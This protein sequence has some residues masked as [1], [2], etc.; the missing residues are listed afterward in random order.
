MEIIADLHLH[1]K[2]S[3]ATSPRMNITDL[4]NAAHVKGVNL[5]GTGD[6]THPKHFADLKRDLTSIG[7][8][9][10]THNN[11]FFMLTSEISLMYTQDGKGRR[12]H[13]VT[14]APD[15]EIVE[16]INERLAKWGRLDYD[17]RP[18][19]GRSCIEYVDEMMKIS[20]E[21]EIIPAHC[22]TPFFGLLG[23]MSG[24]N[25]VEECFGEKSKHIHALETGM[26]SDPSMNWRLSS[27]DKYALVSF[28]DSHSPYPWRLGR[29]ACVFDLKKPSYFELTDAIRNKDHKKFLSTIETSPEYGKY[30]YDGHRDCNVSFSPEE[31]KRLNNICPVCKR[32]L[33][34]GVENRVEEL[35][36]RSVGFM[37]KD[38]IPFKRIIPL[39][40]IICGLLKSSVA[41]KKTELEANKLIASFGS[42]LNVLLKAP[43]SA[44]REISGDKIAEALIKNR[45]GL[46][47]VKPGYDGEY[48]VPIFDEN[49]IIQEKP[50]KASQKTLGEY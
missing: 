34:I 5:L 2:Y 35:A 10:Y 17:G 38:A 33:T 9:V 37:P 31:S 39:H 46:I 26:S 43:E 1:S 22:W 8:G 4:S 16:H 21:I 42:E 32:P 41:S 27:L 12:V 36:D 18:I 44:L 30:H 48:G 14:F 28:S 49:E 11:C 15:L 3:R 13:L 7:N 23:S 24:F 25:S 20:K 47:K 45:N 29:E 6:F 40:E 50:S 19:F